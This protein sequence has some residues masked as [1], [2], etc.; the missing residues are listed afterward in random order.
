[1]KWVYVNR[2]LAQASPGTW[3]I[4]LYALLEVSGR[5]VKVTNL[6]DKSAMAAMPQSEDEDS[7]EERNNAREN[8]AAKA[9]KSLVRS[10]LT[11]WCQKCVWILSSICSPPPTLGCTMV[12]FVPQ[13]Y[14]KLSKFANSL[15]SRSSKLTDMAQSLENE[16]HHVKG[17]D[18]ESP[19]IAR[20]EK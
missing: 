3:P 7:E 1:M 5:K 20:S 14:E 4:R 19:D 13:E 8:S 6:R 18:P 10:Y 16:M 9:R 2:I 15:L 17:K 12:Q 11:I